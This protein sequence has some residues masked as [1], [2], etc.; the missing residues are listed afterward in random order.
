MSSLGGY[1]LA[2]RTIRADALGNPR[3][4]DGARIA[5]IGEI[6]EV[7]ARAAE[8][9]GQKARIRGGYVADRV[10]P[11]CQQA[12]HGLLPGT[13]QPVYRQWRQ[14]ALGL[15]R[16][17]HREAVRLAVGAG[18]LG[19]VL[20]AGNAYRDVQAGG[21]AHRLFDLAAHL[22]GRPEQPLGAAHVEERLVQRQRLH[23]RREIGKDVHHLRRDL[24]I[25]LEARFH[26]DGVR[27]A[28][29]R[30]GHRHGAADAVGPRLVA[31]GEH[32]AAVAVRPHQDRLAA[33]RGIVQLLD[34]GVEGVHVRVNDG[35]GPAVH[36]AS[37]LYVEPVVSVGFQSNQRKSTVYDGFDV[38][39]QRHLCPSVRRD[40][41]R[42]TSPA[43]RTNWPGCSKGFA[44]YCKR[45]IRL[46]ASSS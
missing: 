40:C 12:R 27:T 21:V 19:D 9:I 2:E 24:L 13:P 15:L 35:A 25:A 26:H 28:P 37:I 20:A 23:P 39:H 5:G 46:A 16:R 33:Q 31:G 34:S 41:R 30:L 11:Y 10:Q 18:H 17:H 42:P 38:L 1:V 32:H 43:A 44:V 22:Q 29:P 14:P 4:E 7:T 36:A 8:A 3:T 45:R 6:V